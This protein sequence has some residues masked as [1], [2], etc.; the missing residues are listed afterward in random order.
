VI[1]Q[2][3]F[4][5]RF[6]HWAVIALGLTIIGCAQQEA[7]HQQAVRPQPVKGPV[8]SQLLDLQEKPF[9]LWANS[10]AAVTVAIFTRTDCPISNRYAPEIRRL[11]EQ[12]H[13]KGAEFYLIYV[14][15][16]EQPEQIRKHLR[17]YDYP[18]TA[19]RDP[20]HTFVVQCGAT[21]TPEAIVFARKYSISYRGRIDDLYTEVGQPRDQATTHDLADAIESTLQG[22]PVANPR[23]KAIGC[24]IAD[25]MK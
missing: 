12:Y 24:L 20:G 14:D 7:S 19:L 25:L 21:I 9:D 8:Q 2:R 16:R 10:S 3:C 23:T 1:S 13:P 18:G 22:K 5:R 6:C 4:R 17:E 11:Y 15:P